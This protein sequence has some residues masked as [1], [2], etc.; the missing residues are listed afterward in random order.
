MSRKNVLVILA[1]KM[2]TFV[3][4]PSRSFRAW[5]KTVTQ[6]AWTDYLAWRERVGRGSGDSH[7]VGLLDQVEA[8]EDLLTRLNEEFDRELLEEATVRVRL[9]V[10]PRTWESFQL[11][12]VEGVATPE[13]AR[14]LGIPVA[15]V[16]KYKSRVQKMLQEELRKLDEPAETEP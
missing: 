12:A 9:R 8:R 15:S 2:S 13:V 14:R 6:H 7:V 1:R 5:L 4:D 16:F 3:Y 11:T 10:E